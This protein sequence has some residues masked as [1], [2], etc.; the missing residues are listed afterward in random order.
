MPAFEHEPVLLGRV[1]D[2]FAAVPDGIFVDAT[3]GGAGHAVALLRRTP[4]SAWWASTA[5]PRRSTPR[6]SGS[7]PTPSGA[8]STTPATTGPPRWPGPRPTPPGCPWWLRCSTSGCQLAPARPAPSG[9]S[10][11]ATTRRSTCAWTA[12]PARTAA[13]V[14]NGYDEARPGRR[15]PRRYGDERFAA[16]H[17]P[18]DRGGPADQH[19][20]RAGRASCA[21]PSPRRP[22]DAAATRPSAPSRPSASRSTASSTSSPGALD[23]AIDAARPRRPR[24]RPQLPLGRGPASSRTAFRH[25][26]DRRLHL[27][28][29]P[30]LRVRCHVGRPQRSPA[31]ASRPIADRARRQPPCRKR[32]PAGRRAHR[33][34]AESPMSEPKARESMSNGLLCGAKRSSAHGHAAHRAV[35]SVL[36][37]RMAR[38]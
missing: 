21:T 12:P 36:H 11:T 32:P 34:G 35:V 24:R 31:V 13:D 2:L 33:R 14:V 9:A 3:L 26:V 23:A 7:P 20:G 15:A 10:A 38:P 22:A 16:P 19:H 37:D 29:R 25:A 4:A 17:R 30:A 18:R 28:A 8:R 1:L 27:P 5:T 6:P